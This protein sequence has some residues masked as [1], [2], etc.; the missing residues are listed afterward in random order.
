MELT[1]KVLALMEKSN[2]E[3]IKEIPNYQT[4]PNYQK[5][6]DNVLVYGLKT[7]VYIQESKPNLGDAFF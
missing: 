3:W 6:F 5:I 2:S 4:K 7:R 1:D